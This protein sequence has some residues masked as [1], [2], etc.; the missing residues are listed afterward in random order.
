MKFKQERID[1]IDMTEDRL[2]NKTS[3]INLGNSIDRQTKEQM[4]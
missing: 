1:H 2:P 3:T 4:N